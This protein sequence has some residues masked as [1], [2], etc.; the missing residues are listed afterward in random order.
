MLGSGARAFKFA[1][2]AVLEPRPDLSGIGGD[3]ELRFRSVRTAPANNTATTSSTAD[4]DR[5]SINLPLLPTQNVSLL[6]Y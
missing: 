2:E 3:A 6:L 1:V 5:I 4:S